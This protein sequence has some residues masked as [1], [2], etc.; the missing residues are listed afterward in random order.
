M[1]GQTWKSLQQKRKKG[2]GREGEEEEEEDEEKGGGEAK[3]K[4]SIEYIL[5]ALPESCQTFAWV[6]N[7]V[8]IHPQRSSRHLRTCKQ[9][10]AVS[11]RHIDDPHVFPLRH[12]VGC[13]LPWKKKNPPVITKH[14][15]A[16]SRLNVGATLGDSAFPLQGM[17]VTPGQTHV[18]FCL[19][20]LTREDET[21]TNAHKSPLM[22]PNPICICVS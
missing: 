9:K 20:R 5:P 16:N 4:V 12:Q 1:W 15:G 7:V 17:S 2:R 8:L 18:P 3:H 6:D 13:P 10:S 19:S 21:H 14:E 22:S 11:L